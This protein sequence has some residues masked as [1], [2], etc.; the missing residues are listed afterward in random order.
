MLRAARRARGSREYRRSIG[1]KGGRLLSRTATL[2][3][4]PLILAPAVFAL[5]YVRLYGVDVP[6]NDT[7]TMVPLFDK[8]ASGDLTFVDLFDQQNEHRILF[9]RI[10][11]LALGVATA[12]D[13][14]IVMYAIVGCLVVTMAALLLAFRRSAGANLIL[15]VPVPFLV[16]SFGQYWNLLQAFQIALVF[17]Q[18][19]GVLSLYLLYASQGEDSKRFHFPAAMASGV[20]A[21]FSAAP[22]LPVWPAG[23]LLLLLL[24][25]ARRVRKLVV[26]VWSAVGLLAGFVYFFGFE[27]PPEHTA[28]RYL[29]E[30]PATSVEFFLTMLGSALFREMDLA[31]ATGLLLVFLV[32][33]SLVLLLESGRVGESAFWVSLLPFSLFTLAA[34]TVARGGSGMEN[35]LNAKY[36]TY[37]VLAVIAIYAMLVKSVFGNRQW[38]AM[39][40]LI[41]LTLIV[42][43][44]VPQTYSWG[45]EKGEDARERKE[46]AARVLATHETRPDEDLGILRNHFRTSPETARERISTLEGLDYSVFSEARRREATEIG[47]NARGVFARLSS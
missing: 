11:I 34:T 19:F 6:Y 15:F 16:F 26:G 8:L 14:V 25:G 31:F 35:A 30:E 18:T 10:A 46:E 40:P 21:S 13:N 17:A 37:S 2:A 3:A 47:A 5:L 24:P 20:I 4:L 1:P 42:A 38:S 32:S 9:P 39:A 23:L 33:V 43:W 29:L 12:F 22:G 28:S 7:W 41:V 27:R 45:I 44:S 36:V